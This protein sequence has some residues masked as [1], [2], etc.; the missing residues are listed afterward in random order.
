MA[1]SSVDTKAPLDEPEDEQSTLTFHGTNGTECEDFINNVR[2]RALEQGKI[3]DNDWLVNF[4]KSCCRDGA[5]EFLDSLDDNV[6]GDWKQFRMA[7]LKKYPAPLWREHSSV[8][9]SPPPSSIAR[10]FP[11]PV[12]AAAPATP[13]PPPPPKP[14]GPLPN[15]DPS[16]GEAS[17]RGRTQKFLI[18]GYIKVTVPSA[19]TDSPPF[20][21]YIA[22]SLGSSYG[23]DVQLTLDKSKALLLGYSSSQ[24]PYTVMSIMRCKCG[25]DCLAKAGQPF[26][27][28]SAYGV[29]DF[30]VARWTPSPNEAITGSFVAVDTYTT[31]RV[32]ELAMWIIAPGCDLTPVGI[33]SDAAHHTK[34]LVKPQ[35]LCIRLQTKFAESKAPKLD[36]WKPAADALPF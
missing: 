21:A 13:L 4:A 22:Q 23:G 20:Q 12:P 33:S 1:D 5:L 3:R 27:C 11:E 32:N 26:K 24:K 7:L 9:L 34:V 31:S 18:K 30:L 16:A 28:D 25:K 19:G 15:P 8:L 36:G 6:K 35:G 10:S 29:W 17:F 14:L 2:C